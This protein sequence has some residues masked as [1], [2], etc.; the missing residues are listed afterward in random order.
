MSFQLPLISVSNV[1]LNPSESAEGCILA[2]CQ[3]NPVYFKACWSGMKQNWIEMVTTELLTEHLEKKNNQQTQQQ[4]KDC[5][6]L[7]C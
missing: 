2:F 6:P 1:P 5:C 3:Q 7:P 4:T